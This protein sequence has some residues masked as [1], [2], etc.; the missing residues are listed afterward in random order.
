MGRP[1]LMPTLDM[2]GI[3]SAASR[4]SARRLERSARRI[5]SAEM[6]TPRRHQMALDKELEQQQTRR[7]AHAEQLTSRDQMATAADEAR[8][9]FLN[10]FCMCQLF[11]M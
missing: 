2:S 5:D 3:G 8:K 9:Q 11:G 7:A 1:Q 6:S 4:A 10:V